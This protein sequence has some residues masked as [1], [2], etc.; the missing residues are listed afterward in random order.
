MNQSEPVHVCIYRQGGHMFEMPEFLTLAHQIND[1]MKGKI[2]E[3]GVLGNS[4]HKFV[5]YNRKHKEFEK[6][7]RGKKIGKAHARGNWLF[8]PLDPGYVLI[9]GEFGG[10][11]LYHASGS[12]MPKK[13]HLYLAFTDGSFFTATTQMWGAVELHKKGEEKKR[14]YI[15]GMKLTP[16]D[17]G[18]SFKYFNKLINSLKEKKSAK[19]LLTQDQ[20]IPGIGNAITQDILFKARLHPKFPVHNLTEKQKHTLYKEIVGTVQ[21]VIKKGGRYDEFDLFGNRGGYERLMDKNAAGKPCPE[22]SKK[23]QKIQ[24]LGGACYFCPACQKMD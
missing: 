4:P 13:Y 20:L 3:K 11:V 19:G 15:K 5:W 2:I 8:I 21:S 22:C 18:F 10:K 16:V 14:K 24:Y 23:I 17:K 7:V 9:L 12:D 6:L 1:T